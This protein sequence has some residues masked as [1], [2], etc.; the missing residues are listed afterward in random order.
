MEVEVRPAQIWKVYSWAEKRWRRA[1][2]VNVLVNQVEL[3]YLDMPGAPDLA[4]TFQ[5]DL[6]RMEREPQSYRFVGYMDPANGL[7][8]EG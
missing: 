3:Q 7:V 1:S 8:G 4:R 5:A 2:V 6:R